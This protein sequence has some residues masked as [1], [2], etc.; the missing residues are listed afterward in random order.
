ML[1]KLDSVAVPSSES[2]NETWDSTASIFARPSA[3]E[4]K[5]TTVGEK[6]T[7]TLPPLNFAGLAVRCP[8]KLDVRYQL[9]ELAGG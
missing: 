1:T 2:W 7:T 6:L 3:G 8:C 5:G 4:K 9:G